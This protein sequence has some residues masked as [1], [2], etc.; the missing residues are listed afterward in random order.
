MRL[1]VFV[2][3]V[4]VALM[5]G[6]SSAVSVTRSTGQEGT[7]SK[8]QSDPISGEWS[9]SFEVE[10]ATVEVTFNLKLKG[11]QVTGT[12]DSAHTGPG[13]LSKGTLV[14][15]KIS[16]TMDFSAHE[17]VVVTG[18]LKD[19]VLAGEFATEGTKGTWEVRRK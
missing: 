16:F 3:F 2:I 12:A 14:G 10:G 13:T 8:D 1:R 15:N 11:D 6:A 7:G 4:V 5:A 9:G 18:T 17:S 19:G